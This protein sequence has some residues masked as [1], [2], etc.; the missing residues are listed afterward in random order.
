MADPHVGVFLQG[1]FKTAP[2][3]YGAG[4]RFRG[5]RV[6]V[7]RQFAR[8][9]E[10]VTLTEAEA[11]LQSPWHEDRLLALLILIRQYAKADTGRKAEIFA[12]TLDNKRHINNWDLIDTFAPPIVGAHLANQDRSLLDRLA[13]SS[14]LWDRRIAIIS[15][16][17]FIRHDEFSDTLR[18]A[19]ILL[20]DK[21]DLI[22]K[23]VGWMLREVGKRDLQTEENFLQAHYRNMPR[24]MLRYAI[25]KFPEKRRQQYLCGEVGA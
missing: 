19:T 17:H 9:H 20:T 23:A 21:E 5:I 13:E 10:Q 18:L 7:L 3:G 8:R 1:F 12:L 24:T 14:S 22:H 6:P 2:G 15:T 25:E 16:F 11:L 4:D